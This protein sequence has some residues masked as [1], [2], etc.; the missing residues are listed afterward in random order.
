MIKEETLAFAKEDGAELQLFEE[1]HIL[2]DSLEQE[3]VLRVNA[4]L[5]GIP[6]DARSDFWD[7]TKTGSGDTE[8]VNVKSM[9]TTKKFSFKMA[10]EQS[11]DSET[12]EAP[13]CSV[14]MGPLYS[15]VE[16]WTAEI[17]ITVIK[18]ASGV[19]FSFGKVSEPA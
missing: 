9:V 17:I 10:A 16:G 7:V 3:P 6:D 11:P 8:K 15:S 1:G 5:I 18:G 2:R 19:L 13:Y 12:F 4:T 14:K